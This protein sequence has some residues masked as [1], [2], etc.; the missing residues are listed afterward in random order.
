MRHWT[1]NS[2]D[3][4][5]TAL[6]AYRLT[7]LITVDTLPPVMDARQALEQRLD[8]VAPR[9]AHGPSCPHC[10]GFWASLAT[11]A[12]AEVAHRTGHDRGYRLAA[13]VLASSA[14]VGII[15]DHEAG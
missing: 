1:R 12:A 14:V 8:E 3:L 2:A 11:V 5:V 7:R 6:A 4:I 9:W 15:A 13:A 10:V